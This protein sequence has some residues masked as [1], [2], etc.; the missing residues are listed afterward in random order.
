LF[1]LNSRIPLVSNSSN[2]EVNDRDMHT[3]VYLQNKYSNHIEIRF[4][5]S[6]QKEY[7]FWFPHS[8]VS[9]LPFEPTIFPKLQVNFADFP[10]LRSA[11][12]PEASN[13]E[14]LMRL[15][16]RRRL[17]MRN[18]RTASRHFSRD[19]RNSHYLKPGNSF[20]RRFQESKLVRF[21]I[22]PIIQASKNYFSQQM[23]LHSLCFSKEKKFLT[24]PFFW[25]FFAFMQKRKLCFGFLLPS[26]RLFKSPS[27]IQNFWRN[28]LTHSFR[29]LGVK[30][31]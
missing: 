28:G 31:F 19:R 8:H 11:I 25:M 10:Y 5:T 3:N 20:W 27:H 9:V 7:P 22:Q 13:L 30:E 4:Q 16:V 23:K 18:K 24:F 14:D 29:K 15:S 12:R 1:L 21:W 17:K 26:W 6:I 2:S